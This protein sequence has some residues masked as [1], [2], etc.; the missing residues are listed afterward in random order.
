MRMD[1]WLYNSVGARLVVY[2]L[3]GLFCIAT[4]YVI[5]RIIT[6]LIGMFK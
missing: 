2:T 4:W 5:I 1:K 3:M 6:I